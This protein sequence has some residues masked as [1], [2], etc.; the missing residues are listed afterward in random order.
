MRFNDVQNKNLKANKMIETSTQNLLTLHAYGETTNEQKEFLAGE[1][2][3]DP[4]L[5]EDLMEQIRV[6]RA[7]NNGLKSPSA[8][9]IRIIMEHSYKTEHLQEI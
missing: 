5:Q 4:A 2:I 6:K 7:L 3:K 8:T 9:S 1:L